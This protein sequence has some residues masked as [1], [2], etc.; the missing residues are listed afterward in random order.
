MSP[1][2]D[3]LARLRAEIQRVDRE[4]IGLVAERVRIAGEI[5]ALKQ[6]DARA[7]LDPGREAAVIRAATELG[8]ADGLD[9]EAVREL[10]W[11]LVGMCRRAQLEQG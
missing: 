2:D 7:T 11:T 10:F 1:G 6:E 4:I 3:P 8:R 9:P 5:G